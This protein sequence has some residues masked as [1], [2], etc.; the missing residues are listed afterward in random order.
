VKEK[1]FSTIV[2]S[3]IWLLVIGLL[4]FYTNL[5]FGDPGFVSTSIII[6][7]GFLLAHLFTPPLTKNE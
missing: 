1:I 7:V 4:R 3:L 6:F 2:F 5:V